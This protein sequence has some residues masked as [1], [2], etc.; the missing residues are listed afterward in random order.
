MNRNLRLALAIGA[1][2]ALFAVFAAS[3]NRV[4]TYGSM[5]VPWRRAFLTSFADV[6]PWLA[7]TPVAFWIAGRFLVR[8]ATAWWTVPVL[9]VCGFMLGLLHLVLY[10]NA[11]RW[12]GYVQDPVASGRIAVGRM[13]SDILVCWVLFGIRHAIEYYRRDR[14]REVIASRLQTQLARAQLDVLRAQLQPHFLFNT[15][16]AVSALMHR[17]VEGADRMMARLSDLLRLTLDSAGEQEV[18]LKREMEYLDKYLEIEQVRFGERLKVERAIEA[19]ALDLLVPNFVL[20]PLVENAIRYAIGPRAAGG[21]IEVGAKVTGTELAIEVKDD[22]PGAQGFSEGV[23]LSNTRAR[24]QQLYGGAARLELG[25]AAGGGFR[26]RMVVP[27][28]GVSC[29][30]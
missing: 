23:G 12:L 9:A 2:W 11:L 28:H 13:H 4:T 14:A 16:H 19:R 29:G 24:L 26:A 3:Q 25:N 10:V 21:R 15:L 6:V 5:M 1:A 22:G 17:D 30:S 18:T 20:Q 7:L 8:R 27:G